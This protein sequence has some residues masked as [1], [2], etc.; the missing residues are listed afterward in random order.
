M[1]AAFRLP[2]LILHHRGIYFHLLAFI[3]WTAATD[4]VGLVLQNAHVDE[5]LDIIIHEVLLCED[6]VR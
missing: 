2:T 5:S 1:T 4:F 6:R 3:K